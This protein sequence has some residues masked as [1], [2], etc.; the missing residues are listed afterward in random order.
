MV[1]PADCRQNQHDLPRDPQSGKRR[2]PCA[3]SL[4]S[5]S[6]RRHGKT[7]S[8]GLPF[9]LPGSRM[10]RFVYR[11]VALCRTRGPAGA[12]LEPGMPGRGDGAADGAGCGGGGQVHGGPRATHR[13]VAAGSRGGG[14]G[15]RS[16]R[17]GGVDLPRAAGLPGAAVRA[18]RAPRRGKYPS[19]RRHPAV[20]GFAHRE[21]LRRERPAPRSAGSVR[22]GRPRIRADGSPVEDVQPGWRSRRDDSRLSAGD[23]DLFAHAPGV[24]QRGL[25]A[26]RCR[27][28]SAAGGPGRRARLDGRD[29]ARVACRARVPGAA[30]RGRLRPAR[31]RL[32]RGARGDSGCAAAIGIRRVRRDRRSSHR[33]GAYTRGRR[34]ARLRVDARSCG[35]RRRRRYA[36]HQRRA[37][38]HAAS[39]ERRPFRRAA[40]ARGPG[41]RRPRLRDQR[42]PRAQVARRR[43]RAPARRAPGARRERRAERLVHAARSAQSRAAIPGARGLE[44]LAA[45]D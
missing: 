29:D 16:A 7:L 9:A 33:R 24:R 6:C 43:L 37:D 39:L 19:R 21:R 8:Q 30:A 27:R 36:G 4:R 23:G 42:G 18:A 17:D 45:A 40:P 31:R 41:A 32:A 1:D 28:R 13:A 38:I 22:R 20:R 26:P 25:R 10:R 5:K 35:G 11:A 2:P 3:G 12:S 44:D 14:P 34:G 15:G